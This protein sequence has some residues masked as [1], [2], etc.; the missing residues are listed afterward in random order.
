MFPEFNIPDVAGSDVSLAALTML[1]S[2]LLFFFVAPSCA[3]CKTLVPEFEQWTEELEGKV[4]A[5][6]VSSGT[7]SE[8]LA[9]FGS[10]ISGAMLLQ[11]GRELAD[12]AKAQWT[13]TAVLVDS[14]G[15]VASHTAAGDTA[16]RELVEK[17]R[18]ETFEDKLTYITNGHGHL[19]NAKLGKTIPQFMLSDDKGNEIS[20]ADLKGKKTLVAFW[21]LTCP[22]C[23]N[24][25][26]DLRDWERTKADRMSPI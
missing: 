22:H 15:R 25:M 13:P 14:N 21:S 11:K 12:A 5:V 19:H 3:P 6:F 2:P 17:I 7:A 10:E 16:I 9:K 1:G 18:A 26:D 8:N 24:M 4:R 20:D 23:L